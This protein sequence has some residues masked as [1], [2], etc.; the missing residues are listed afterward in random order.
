MKDTR[1]TVRDYAD[2][3]YYLDMCRLQYER[4]KEDAGELKRIE[5][6]MEKVDNLK[7]NP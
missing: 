5:D 1:L 2:I 7:F 3:H 6:L 4:D